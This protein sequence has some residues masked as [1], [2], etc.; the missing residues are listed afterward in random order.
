[1]AYTTVSK[2][3][4]LTAD[5]LTTEDSILISS[6]DRSYKA[7]LED[8]K[9]FLER[10]LE[11][12]SLVFENKVID[13]ITNTIHAT[14]LHFEGVAR[15]DLQRGDVVTLFTPSN[16]EDD[17]FLPEVKKA[18]RMNGPAL[19]VVKDEFVP[20]GSNC[21][22]MGG[23]IFT[24]PEFD[25]SEF[26]EG[27]ILWLGL[28]GKFQAEKPGNTDGIHQ[29]CGF[30]LH[31]NETDGALMLSFQSIE[32]QGHDVAFAGFEYDLTAT[33]V[34]HGIA[35]VFSLC[36]AELITVDHQIIENNQFMVISY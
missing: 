1:M 26:E 9:T 21:A 27:S 20:A 10:I 23:G 29:A 16:G 28:D 32:P 13:S 12:S 8:L 36:D 2:L 15:E 19:G 17:G 24:S 5:T 3:T 14:A 18:S 25:T 30:V 11:I 22:V 4:G 34:E 33:D 31:S 6:G 35:E 7:N